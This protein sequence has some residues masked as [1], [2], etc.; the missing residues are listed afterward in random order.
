M[1]GNRLLLA[2]GQLAASVR[3]NFPREILQ[4]WR[5]KFHLGY[6]V[7]HIKQ[8]ALALYTFSN[9][10]RLTSACRGPRSKTRSEVKQL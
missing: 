10:P 2:K 4:I 1:R 7:V 9:Y 3:A 5:R 6:T 8:G